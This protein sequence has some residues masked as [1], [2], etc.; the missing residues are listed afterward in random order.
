MGVCGGRLST[1]LLQG[2]PMAQ[3]PTSSQ[4]LFQSTSLEERMAGLRLRRVQ[5]QAQAQAEGAGEVGGVL[6]RATSREQ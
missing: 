3:P 2:R 6:R 4:A 5:A 1:G